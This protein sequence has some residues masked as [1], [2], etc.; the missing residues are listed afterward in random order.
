[1]TGALV[2]AGTPAATPPT[3]APLLLAPSSKPAKK[4]AHSSPTERGS[5]L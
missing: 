4:S 1:M 3:A 2:A 5:A